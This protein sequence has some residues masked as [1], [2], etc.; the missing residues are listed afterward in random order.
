MLAKFF[1][2]LLSKESKAPE[3]TNCS[4]T[5]RLT[6]G[7]RAAKSKMSKNIPLTLRSSRMSSTIFWLI[8]LIDPIPMRIVCS[9]GTVKNQSLT[10]TSGG[11]KVT[12]HSLASLMSTLI[13]SP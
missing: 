12:P 4:N 8:P 9:S 1:P 5:L 2:R 10:L 3:R 7:T 13:F 6:V 11:R